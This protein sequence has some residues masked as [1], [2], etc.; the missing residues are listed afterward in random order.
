MT[1]FIGRRKM[2]EDGVKNYWKEKNQV[3]I[4]GKPTKIL[5]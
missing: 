3:S 4:D 5:K 1:L 2:G